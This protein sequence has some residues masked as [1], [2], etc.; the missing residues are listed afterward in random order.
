MAVGVGEDC[1]HALM[2]SICF[3]MMNER[4]AA[5]FMSFGCH[6]CVPEEKPRVPSVKTFFGYLY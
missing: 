6:P 5:L 2:P 4:E 1:A 3:A